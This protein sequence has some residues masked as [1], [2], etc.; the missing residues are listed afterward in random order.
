MRFTMLAASLCVT[1]VSAQAV[2]N[3]PN[4]ASV[5]AVIA[6]A[7]PGDFVQLSTAHPPFSLDKG[8][9]VVGAAGGTTIDAGIIVRVPAGQRAS[10]RGVSIRDWILQGSWE[11]T[12]QLI[13]GQCEVSECDGGVI[14]VQG[15]NHILQHISQQ[16][17]TRLV[18]S[19]GLC[20]VTDSTF[21]PLSRW[22]LAY[23]FTGNP[24]IYQDGGVL[25]ASRVIASGTVGNPGG[26]DPP[27]EGAQIGMDVQAGIAYLTDCALY[28]GNV[29]FGSTP[30]APALV[31]RQF[32]HVARTT[33]VDGTG[34]TASSGY[35][36]EPQ[37][38]GMSCQ[39]TPA[40]GGSFTAVAT[41]GNSQQPLGI[42][43]GFSGMP[44][45]PTPFVE[46][47][48]GSPGN[49]VSVLVAF[50]A[51]SATVSATV[52]VPNV[53]ALRGLQVWLQAAQI[54]GA[55]IRASAVVGGTIR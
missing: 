10:L 55:S 25:I 52:N 40:L 15:G 28:G 24:G 53:L 6:Q 26:W 14:W 23:G 3:V 22:T 50:P 7:A 46:P 43:G 36:V 39:G 13:S 45:T 38:V 51:P 19:A 8:V 5:D 11:G 21:N 47:L 27:R 48:F 54:A 49:L 37:M 2:W 16:G 42:L 31:G 33:L 35:S 4:N 1:S 34:A 44:S 30:A 41:A 20:S 17:R 29:G 12:L 9:H 18:M 32:V